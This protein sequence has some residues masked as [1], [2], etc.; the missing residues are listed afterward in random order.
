MEMSR[1]FC[2]VCDGSPGDRRGHGVSV[3]RGRGPAGNL[4]R[5]SGSLSSAH[6]VPP[7]G[8]RGTK[9]R[10][11][12]KGGPQSTLWPQGAMRPGSPHRLARAAAEAR[13]GLLA[14]ARSSPARPT[15]DTTPADPSGD[16]KMVP[17]PAS[18][19]PGGRRRGLRSL[20]PRAR[21][22]KPHCELGTEQAPW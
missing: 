20:V 4:R 6:R 8:P 19:W 16:M 9:A 15:G 22:R 10:E 5:S 11:M 18:D 1:H 7:L 21:A 2:S 17:S 14:R 12:D 3:T 13:L